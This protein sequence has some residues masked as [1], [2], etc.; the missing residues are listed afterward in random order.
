[1]H[2]QLPIRSKAAFRQRCISLNVSFSWK[3]FVLAFAAAS[4]A[5]G[6]VFAQHII[7]TDD[8]EAMAGVMLRKGKNKEAL[9]FMN[10]AI[11]KDA[12]NAVLYSNRST[13]YLR[14]GD[15]KKASDDINRAFVLA[16][17]KNLSPAQ[18]G[19]LYFNRGSI[20]RQ[21][22]RKKEA[23]LDIKQAAEICPLNAGAHLA[24]AEMYQENG[25]KAQALQSYNDARQLY[26]D[27]GGSKSS[28]AE[29]DAKIT[30][31]GGKVEIREQPK[32]E[33]KLVE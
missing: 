23:F 5:G 26:N 7:S 33:S 6:D 22:K 25:S 3:P 18:K 16:K 29:I 1:M 27:F 14:L 12:Q 4:V 28:L 15:L 11:S 30:N 10:K 2:D 31:L 17:G 21:L 32:Q 13:C 20:Y 24:L 8:N 19:M 9:Q